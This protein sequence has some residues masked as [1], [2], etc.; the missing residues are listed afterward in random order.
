MTA[1]QNFDIMIRKDRYRFVAH[2]L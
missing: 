2:S 1:Y